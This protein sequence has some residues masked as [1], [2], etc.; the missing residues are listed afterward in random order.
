MDEEERK[1]Q[2][3]RN[4]AAQSTKGNAKQMMKQAMLSKFLTTATQPKVET[5]AVA[6]GAKSARG[7][8]NQ[9]KQNLD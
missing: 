9:Q 6:K 3:S 1:T 2:R 4:E 7:K 8:T 5:P